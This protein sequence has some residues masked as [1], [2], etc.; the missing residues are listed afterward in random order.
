MKRFPKRYRALCIASIATAIALGSTGSD[1]RG[2]DVVTLSAGR[3]VTP[4]DIAAFDAA[5]IDGQKH[6]E[7]LDQAY[8]DLCVRNG[9]AVW[10][11]GY[12]MA[13][14]A[15]MYDL[16]REPRYVSQLRAFIEHALLFRDDHHPGD[17]CNSGQDLPQH[18]VDEF[19]GRTV[20]GWGAK[21]MSFGGLHIADEVISSLYAS[22]IAAFARIVA[23]NAALHA[24]YG[25]DAVKYTNAVLETVWL[26]MPQIALELSRSML[27]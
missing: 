5:W 8:W 23:E 17:I 26:F 10:G 22:P 9:A 14:M 16:T 3:T 24:E 18:P 13:A 6:E 1:V 11:T 12:R 2:A 19:R 7:A 15:H 21:G 25:N 20:P 4:A 27:K